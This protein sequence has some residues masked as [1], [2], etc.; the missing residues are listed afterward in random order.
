M[1]A[2]HNAL[3]EEGTRDEL[4]EALE[5]AWDELAALKG[6]ETST[7]RALRTVAKWGYIWRHGECSLDKVEEAIDAFIKVRG[8]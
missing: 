6:E 1:G 4:L 8:K 5:K 2:Y 7:Q 3:R